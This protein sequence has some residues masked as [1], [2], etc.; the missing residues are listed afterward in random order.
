M[1]DANYGTA[2][3]PAAEIIFPSMYNESVKN[4]ARWE[5]AQYSSNPVRSSYQ[6]SFGMV[7]WSKRLDALAQVAIVEAIRLDKQEAP[8]REVELHR[9]Q[10]EERRVQQ[11]KARLVNKPSFRP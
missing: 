3:R 10:E 1:I 7:V 8:Q 11:E 2:A 5:D 6:P 9:K 4:L